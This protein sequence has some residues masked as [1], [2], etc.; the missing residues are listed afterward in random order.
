MYLYPHTH[1][2]PLHVSFFYFDNLYRWSV[3][4]KTI[5]CDLT[6]SVTVSNI[7]LL[8]RKTFIWTANA[9]FQKL[10]KWSHVFAVQKQNK[11]PVSNTTTFLTIAPIVVWTVWCRPNVM[12]RLVIVVITAPTA[13][14]KNINM[15]MSIPCLKVAKDGDF[16]LEKKYLEG[17][18]LCSI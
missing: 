4:S 16:A 14:F 2:T 5:N 15:H 18:L 13:N 7:L 6:I 8:W 12:T 3:S 9:N 11:T 17:L 10:T 1:G